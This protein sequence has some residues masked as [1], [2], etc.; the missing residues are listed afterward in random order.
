MKHLLTIAIA[1]VAGFVGAAVWSL[2]GLG[3]SQTRDYLVANPDILPEMADAYRAQ[4]AKDALAAV[5][6]DVR[7]PF[8][9]AVLGNPQGSKVLVKFTDYACGYCRVSVADVDRLIAAD[10]DLKVVIRERAT[11]PGSEP[12]ARMALAAA[13]QGRYDAF[14]HAMFDLGSPSAETVAAAARQVDLD[15]EAALEFGQSEA[16]TQEL[17]R[18][19]ELAQ[20][21][22]IPGTPSWIFGDRVFEG[23][24]GYD[25]MARIVLGD[26]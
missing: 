19:N 2:T 7:E 25:E 24:V 5:S 8:A 10:P 13:N 1:L 21:L 11:F 6:R 18:N 9:G 23:A 16:V 17:I 12:A 15:M 3:N 20:T 4:E 22:N 14:Y 26:G